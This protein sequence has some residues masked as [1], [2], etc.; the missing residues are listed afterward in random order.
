MI[1]FFHSTRSPTIA[2]ISTEQNVALYSL[3][4]LKLAKFFLK[5]SYYEMIT[6]IFTI[7]ANQLGCIIGHRGRMS[8][9]KKR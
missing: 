8:S 7:K 5:L 2:M 1:N 4:T 9:S 3:L 6:S